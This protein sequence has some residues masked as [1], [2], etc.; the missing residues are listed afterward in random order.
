MPPKPVPTD[1][2]DTA[3]HAARAAGAELAGAPG[4]GTVPRGC[5]IE[6]LP[7]SAAAC[8]PFCALSQL[9]A[10]CPPE[11]EEVAAVA[12][13]PVAAPQ[14]TVPRAAAAAVPA[15]PPRAH[16][17]DLFSDSD[18]DE[19]WQRTQ[20]VEAA[21]APASS[22]KPVAVPAPA[23]PPPASAAPPPVRKAVAVGA[24]QMAWS[25]PHALA[26]L[27]LRCDPFLSELGALLCA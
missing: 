13:A 21:A 16:S 10:A 5:L 23:P 14:L 17:P 15:R 25:A 27:M 6:P 11:E 7:A 8:E 12:A 22:A 1:V 26:A 18:S 9:L 20:A 3:V 19:E 24:E 2:A 4:V